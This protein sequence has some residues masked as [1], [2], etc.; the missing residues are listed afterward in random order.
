MSAS[1]APYGLS[2]VRNQ[3]GI[4]RVENRVDGIQSG[5][6]NNFYTGTPIK[7]AGGFLV[8]CVAGADTPLGVFQG[9]EFSYLG[10]RWVVPWLQSGQTYDP[11]TM[12]AKYTMDP[13]IVYE[14]QANG[15]LAATAVGA[16]INLVGAVTGNSY[17]GF[18]TQAL[19]ATTTG[20]TAGSFKIVGL[21][22]APDNAWGDAFTRVEVVISSY[23]GAAA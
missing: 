6:S 13:E 14:G 8:P 5:G 19:N 2:P 18:S 15:S 16:S 9:V 3:A 20:A 21:Y 4:V 11:G 22:R 1:A 7:N 23:Q 17:T 12:I 10:K